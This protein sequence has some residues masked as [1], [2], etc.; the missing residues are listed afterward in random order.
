MSHNKRILR[1]GYSVL[2]DFSWIANYKLRQPNTP[3]FT[4]IDEVSDIIGKMSSVAAEITKLEPNVIA[5][6]CH[7]HSLNLNLKS[8]AEQ[9]Q[10]LKDTL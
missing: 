3:K 6:H 2:W 8:S 7:F 10:L 9:C 1:K 5:A 4:N